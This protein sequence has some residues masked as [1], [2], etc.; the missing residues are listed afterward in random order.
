MW[1]E[2]ISA[3]I[4][5]LLTSAIPWLNEKTTKSIPAENW[6]NKELQYKDRLNGMSEKDIVKN[7]QN[8]RYYRPKEVSQAYP[9]PHRE[10]GGGHRIIIENDELHDADVAQYG[11]YLAQKWTEQGKYNLTP[12]ELEIVRFQIRRRFQQLYSL[13]NSDNECDLTSK[14][15]DVLLASKHWDCRKT[16]AALQWEKIHATERKYH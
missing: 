1:F 12:E 16:E 7:A 4:V 10:S 9:V 6:A 13:G 5:A 15:K 2:P 3:W 11:A 14:E 8:G